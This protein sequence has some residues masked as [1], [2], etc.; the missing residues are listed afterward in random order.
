MDEPWVKTVDNKSMLIPTVA[1]VQKQAALHRC[2]E[3]ADVSAIRKSLAAQFG[4]YS[5][6]PV[7]V[8]RHLKALG[9]PARKSTAKA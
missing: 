6:C 9:I 7:T 4:T 1:L 5:T 8:R 3:G 2:A